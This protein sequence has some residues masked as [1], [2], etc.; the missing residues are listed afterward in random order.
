M[1]Y[2]SVRGLLATPFEAVVKQGRSVKGDS[3]PLVKCVVAFDYRLN[4][5]KAS[6]NLVLKEVYAKL[7]KL[8]TE[9]QELKQTYKG[10]NENYVVALSS[11]QELTLQSAQAAKRAAQSAENSRQAAHNATLAAQQAASESIRSISETAAKAAAAATAVAQQAEKSLLDAS[12]EASNASKMASQAAAEAVTLSQLAADSL[13]T[14][15]D[16]DKD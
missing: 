9:F 16:R 12:V 1:A 4:S 10:M 5:L 3:H 13:L 2:A 14:F 6:M 8:E 11:L 7:T 15:K